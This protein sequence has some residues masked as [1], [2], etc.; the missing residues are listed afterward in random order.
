MIPSNILK[1]E[2]LRKEIDSA[3]V[4]LYNAEEGL[5]TQ[6]NFYGK[7]EELLNIT[8][9]NDQFR[10]EIKRY[11]SVMIDLYSRVGRGFVNLVNIKEVEGV[12]PTTSAETTIYDAIF[13]P[14]IDKPKEPVLPDLELTYRNDFEFLEEIKKGIVSHHKKELIGSGNLIKN[15]DWYTKQLN[16][17]PSVSTITKFRFY[18]TRQSYDYDLIDLI[19]DQEDKTKLFDLFLKHGFTDYENKHEA[20]EKYVGSIGDNSANVPNKTFEESKTNFKLKWLAGKE[21]LAELVYTLISKGYIEDFHLMGLERKFYVETLFDA[22]DL[23]YSSKTA[24]SNTLENFY[25]CFKD[26]S[27]VKIVNKNASKKKFDTIKRKNYS[28]RTKNKNE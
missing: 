28:E 4:K 21:D 22:F 8:G 24:N 13:D 25:Q 2:R 7:F 27:K 3:L 20:F 18:V 12:C 1:I 23:S 19:E 14:E 11:L 6:Y 10:E 26:E 15:K 17:Q 5:Y 16:A 9:V